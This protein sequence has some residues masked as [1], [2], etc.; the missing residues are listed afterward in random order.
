ME[1]G[2]KVRSNEKLSSQKNDWGKDVQQN[3]TAQ[4]LFH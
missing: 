4:R 2:N 1:K 3:F